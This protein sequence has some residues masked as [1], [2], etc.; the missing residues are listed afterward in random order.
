MSA[1]N[2]LRLSEGDDVAIARHPLSAVD[3]LGMPGAL[4]ALRATGDVPRGHR[5]ALRDVRAGDLVRKDGHVIG[6][7]TVPIRAGELGFGGEEF[8]PWQLGAVL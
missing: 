2:V 7:A 6:V 5:I 1:P 4:G 8:I 3:P